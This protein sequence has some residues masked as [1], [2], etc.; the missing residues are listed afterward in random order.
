MLSDP[1]WAPGFILILY[2][3][4][5]LGWCLGWGVWEGSESWNK[6]PKVSHIKEL[7]RESV[8]VETTKVPSKPGK[9]PVESFTRQR[10]YLGSG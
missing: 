10:G 2:V 5:T 3:L 4:G 6:E 7:G 8:K 9:D 1:H